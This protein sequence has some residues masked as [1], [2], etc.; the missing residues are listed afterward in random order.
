M[1]AFNDFTKGV[2]S[3]LTGMP[4]QQQMPGTSGWNTGQASPYS[5]P[6]G[7][8]QLGQQGYGQQQPY[9]QQGQQQFSPYGQ[10]QQPYGQQGQQ[11]YGQQ[12]YP[13]QQQFSPYGQPVQQPTYVYQTTDTTPVLHEH[14]H[15]HQFPVSKV[16][17]LYQFHETSWV[18]W[19]GIASVI[20]FLLSV[21]FIPLAWRVSGNFLFAM[22]SLAIVSGIQPGLLAVRL[23]SVSTRN[24]L[25]AYCNSKL[26][27]CTGL[28]IVAATFASWVFTSIFRVLFS[29]GTTYTV[30]QLV[31]SMTCIST[32]VATGGS[33]IF[34]GVLYWHS[35]KSSQYS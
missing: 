3:G 22:S 8:Q 2:T 27:L 34:F 29:I 33:M 4:Q 10:Q 7:G 30:F 24:I 5:S 6:Y 17:N 1:Q 25:E 31:F 13:Q 28:F 26:V 32:V 9:G 14:H 16:I 12:G 23:I 21:A 11:Q 19:S 18:M 15:D 35:R 20:C